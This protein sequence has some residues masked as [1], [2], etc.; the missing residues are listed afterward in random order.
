V[1][2]FRPGFG[3]IIKTLRTKSAV[4]PAL[5]FSAI[6]MLTGVF[7]L[8]FAPESVAINFIVTIAVGLLIPA[9]QITFFTAYYRDRLQD[10]EH[11]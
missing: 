10:E 6:C 2:G 7:C 9:L 5:I 3:E 4:N 8:I 1:N 11:V